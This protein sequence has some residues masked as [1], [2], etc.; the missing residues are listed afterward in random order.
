MTLKVRQAARGELCAAFGILGLEKSFMKQFCMGG[1]VDNDLKAEDVLPLSEAK[2][3]DDIYISGVVVRDPHTM[4]GRRRAWVMLWAMVIY[5]R[6]VYGV[7]RRR[8]IF[9]L[10]VNNDSQNLLENLGFSIDCVAKHRR[11][12]L[13]LYRLEL[14]RENLD[15]ILR[16]VGDHSLICRF[17]LPSG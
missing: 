6:L 8:N 4:Q 5:I 13:S 12:D 2:R 7:K 10:A 1:V 14:S 15:R 11:D 17:E 9:A 16:R 3:L